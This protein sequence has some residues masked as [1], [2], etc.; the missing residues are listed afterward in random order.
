MER[1]GKQRPVLLNTRLA[2]AAK[3]DKD[4]RVSHRGG[5]R[6]KNI[7]DTRTRMAWGG[8][9]YGRR[10]I[11]LELVDIARIKINFAAPWLGIRITAVEQDPCPCCTSVVHSE[12]SLRLGREAA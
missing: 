9:L 10:R 7:R 6:V 4:E 8:V 5:H 3:G 12:H 11:G 2:P 1:E